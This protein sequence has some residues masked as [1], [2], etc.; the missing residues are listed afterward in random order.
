MN[1]SYRLNEYRGNLKLYVA[2]RRRI[3]LPTPTT[4]TTTTEELVR[5]YTL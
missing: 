3:T 1:N 2:S 5:L 4:T